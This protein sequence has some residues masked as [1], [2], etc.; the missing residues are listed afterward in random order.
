MPDIAATFQ[1]RF[2]L[3]RKARKM[4]CKVIAKKAGYHDSYIY[5]INNRKGGY[6]IGI[7]SAQILAEV[8]DVPLG[9]LLGMIEEME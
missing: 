3:A 9:Y 6:N 7:R 5:D 2:R 1:Q 8:L 4:N